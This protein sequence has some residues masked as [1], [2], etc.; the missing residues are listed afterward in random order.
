MTVKKYRDIIFLK[1]EP[2]QIK[3][4][5]Y[6]PANESSLI[7][8]MLITIQMSEEGQVWVS[9]PEEA[10]VIF[11]TEYSKLR[12]MHQRFGEEKF[13]VAMLVH[14]EGKHANENKRPNVYIA[15]KPELDES[16]LHAG[17]AIATKFQEWSK[18]HTQKDVEDVAKT[19]EI[20]VHNIAGLSRSYRV[21]VVD[22]K[23]MNLEIAMAR[24]VGQQMVLADSPS[25]AM[26]Y[27]E[28][29]AG[30]KGEGSFDA[31]LTDLNMPPD[32]MYGALNLD[33]YALD[34]E[35]PAGISIM[36]EA[37]KRG[38]PVA[39]VTDANHHR[40]WF[41][42]MFDSHKEATVNGKKVVFN[43]SGKQ[44]DHALKKLVEDE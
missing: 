33:Q 6:Y 15:E 40:D 24:L 34:D 2:N 35:V 5:K 39:I 23:H 18:S 32:K 41:S 8:A 25:N 14:S 43:N 9:T 3:K 4:M 38:I 16:P 30:E 20:S 22:D 29:P 10:D 17:V 27:L 13:L 42:A 44:W 36:F 21:L 19:D 28:L 11:T 37:T 12:E 1:S 31:V 26:K 7:N